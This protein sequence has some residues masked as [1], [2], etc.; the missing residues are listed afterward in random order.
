MEILKD[1]SHKTSLYKFNRIQVIQ[2]MFSD[3]NEIKLQ[4]ITERYEENY[5]ILEN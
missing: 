5:Q 2:R 3:H 4:S 1:K